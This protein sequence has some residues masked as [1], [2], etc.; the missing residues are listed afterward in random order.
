LEEIFPYCF[1][2]NEWRHDFLEDIEVVEVEIY[3]V[4]ANP[5]SSYFSL[6]FDLSSFPFQNL[7]LSGSSY[8]Y[9]D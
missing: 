2:Q 3:F 7:D 9:F 5:D 1:F 8:W 6:D 4:L